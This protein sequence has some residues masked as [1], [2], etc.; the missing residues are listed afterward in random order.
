MSHVFDALKQAETERSGRS[1]DV[2]EL[3]DFA[4]QLLRDEK[5]D[6]TWMDEVQVVECGHPR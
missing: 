2:S 4:T 5:S 3:G 6:H 1:L